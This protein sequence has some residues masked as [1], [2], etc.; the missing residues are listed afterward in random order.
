MEDTSAAECPRAF[1]LPQVA[2]FRFFLQA[3][4]PPRLPPYAGSIWRGLL[5][6]GL[7]RA[8][9]VTRQ[10]SCEGGLLLHAC[11]Y[12]MLFESPATLDPLFRTPE[13][14]D[15]DGRVGELRLRGPGLATF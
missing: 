3:L 5:G 14:H 6:L 10:P 9:C 7:R 13:R 15:E 1:P 8:A 11:V 12:S 4:E 2:G